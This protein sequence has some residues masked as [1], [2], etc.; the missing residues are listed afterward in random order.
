MPYATQTRLRWHNASSRTRLLTLRQ[1][2]SPP[3]CTR[4][5]RH[6]AGGGWVA[7]SS[8]GRRKEP[9]VPHAREEEEGKG[10]GGLPPWGGQ[11]ICLPPGDALG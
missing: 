9:H 6:L 8:R 11:H 5:G 3:A 2:L 4:C 10:A 7:A 1:Y